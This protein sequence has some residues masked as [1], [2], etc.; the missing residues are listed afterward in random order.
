MGPVRAGLL[1]ALLAGLVLPAAGAL[2]PEEWASLQTARL[3]SSLDRDPGAAIAVYEAL[4]EHQDA[5]EPGRGEV[6]YWLARALAEDGRDEEAVRVMEQAAR[7]SD[8][9]EQARS[10]QGLFEISRNPVRALPYAEGFEKNLGHVVRGWPRGMAGDLGI[11][12]ENP[13]K[14]FLR[15]RTTVQDGEEDWLALGLAEGASQLGR[16]RVRA[17]STAFESWLQITLLGDDG[18]AWSTPAIQVPADAWRDI[19]VDL[20]DFFPADPAAAVSAGRPGRIQRVL[21]REVTA[22]YA[23]SR[24]QHAV[25][26]DELELLPR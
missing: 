19:N 13:R 11:D 22:F 26:L 14:P 5:T 25:H 24:G 23:R 18:R 17:R 12:R 16:V 4:L 3:S 8:A 7:V 20:D 1:A 15:W 2:T 9:R 10:W 21:V 6:L